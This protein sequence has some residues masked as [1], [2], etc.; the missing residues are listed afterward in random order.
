MHRNILFLFA[1]LLAGCGSGGGGTGGAGANSLTGDFQFT[2]AEADAATGSSSK[3]GCSSAT[4][5]VRFSD[6]CEGGNGQT[7]DVAEHVAPG[8]T[9]QTGTFQIADFEC[10]SGAPTASVGY[11]ALYPDGGLDSFDATSGT[12]SIASIGAGEFPD[13]K[14]TF[15]VQFALADG[16]VLSAKGAFDT[17]S[18][19]GCL[20]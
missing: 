6:T 10:G 19:A 8:G 16:G 7:F 12:V 3:N 18:A 14:G 20:Q 13:L 1:A 4:N 17:A 15:D 2:L 11:E 9:P 5:S